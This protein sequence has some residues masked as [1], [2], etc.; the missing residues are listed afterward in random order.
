MTTT[1]AR[2]ATKAGPSCVVSVPQ[3]PAFLPWRDA[4]GWTVGPRREDTTAPKARID[5]VLATPAA[6]SA[7][8]ERMLRWWTATALAALAVISAG[9]AGGAAPTPAGTRY[10]PGL[11]YSVVI[12]DSLGLRHTTMG[13]G[14]AWIRSDSDVAITTARYANAAVTS[15][16]EAGTFAAGPLR[17]SGGAA[18]RTERV[19][20]PAGQA[21][22]VTGQTREGAQ[23][24]EIAWYHAGDVYLLTFVDVPSGQQTQV[25]RS[26][27]FN[28]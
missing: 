11:G 8:R 26:F 20:L 5:R 21:Y 9:C 28:N 10:D 27:A 14:D 18:T 12:P 17:V 25:E 15:L 24:V 19:N 1:D 4:C 13:S 22:E 6:H 16:E 7:K 23:T 3:L 2:A